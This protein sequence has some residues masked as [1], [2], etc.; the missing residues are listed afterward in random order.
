MLFCSLTQ[1]CRYFW[2]TLG[3][4]GHISPIFCLCGKKQV[5]LCNFGHI[6]N[7][8]CLYEKKE[9]FLCNFSNIL[10]V[11]MEKRYFCVIL[12]IL[13]AIVY[14]NR[15][16]CVIFLRFQSFLVDKEK[17]VFL[18]NFNDFLFI[19]IDWRYFCVILLSFCW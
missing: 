5:F 15:Y 11:N 18:C 3:N 19:N 9:V 1:Y 8:F 12:M 17:E 6:L 16:F 4:F 14:Q 10:S 2:V 13:Y 7:I